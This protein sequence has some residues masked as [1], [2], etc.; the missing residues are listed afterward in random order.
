DVGNQI[1]LASGAL[2][3]L[4]ADG[5]YNYD[6]NGQFEA[7]N[8][9]ETDT[10]TFSYTVDDGNGGTDTAT[11]NVTIDGVNDVPPN[12][13]ESDYTIFN[14]NVTGTEFTVELASN[15][16]VYKIN[17]IATNESL[18]DFLTEAVLELGGTVVKN[19]T[20]NENALEHF[21]GSQNPSI[22][23][24]ETTDE[25]IIQ[26]GGSG[27]GG[28][29]K[30]EFD[31]D[32]DANAFQE[33][34]QDLLGTD[35]TKTQIFQFNGDTNGGGN[36]IKI[37]T[38]DEIISLNP[39]LSDGLRTADSLDFKWSGANTSGTQ[40]RNNFDD[41]IGEM[42]DLFGGDQLTNANIHVIPTINEAQLTGTQVE[43]SNG[44]GGT[45]TWD[46]NN[47]QEAQNFLTFFDSTVD[48]FAV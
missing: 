46:F 38:N 11:V 40:V 13:L 1:T 43:I 37:L 26:I 7:L 8:D 6:P 29:Y 2:L 35:P 15:N 47:E 44:I 19:G 10:D 39:D 33:F 16:P 20:I 12:S 18:N 27:V 22:T 4:N 14:R 36:N 41:F 25:V 42:G 3:T 5:S 48:A 21:G 28:Q 34:A 30:A 32:A 45:E 31:N 24:N 23:E 9:G 17:D